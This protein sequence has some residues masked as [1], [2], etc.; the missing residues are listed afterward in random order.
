MLY[1]RGGFTADE[2]DKLRKHTHDMSFDEIYSPGLFYDGTADRSH[3]WTA[4]S[5][6]FSR[7]AE[8][9]AALRRDAKPRR[10]IRTAPP[11]RPARP[12]RPRPTTSRPA[13]SADDG[14]LPST[15]MGR[16][17]W[18]TLVNGDWPD[19]AKR[20]VFDT[21]KLT[22]DAP[23]FAA[24]VKTAGSAGDRSIPTGWSCCRTNGAIC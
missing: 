14:V 15:V 22:N 13:A 18:H 21:R 3:A 12:T 5:R 16:L 6:R 23:Y 11:I 4:M 19:I 17:A 9:R 10:P 2:I 1:K 20:Y 8:Q 7:R 24:Y